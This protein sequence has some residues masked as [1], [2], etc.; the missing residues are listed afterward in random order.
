MPGNFNITFADGTDTLNLISGG[1]V[2]SANNN[3]TIGAAVDSGR[4]TAGG[5]V[6]NSDLFVF[7]NQATLTINSRI[8]DNSGGAV[9]L[10]KSGAG[11]VTLTN[12]ANSY[13]G[14][15]IVNAG[16]LNLSNAAASA[17]IPAGGLTIGSAT[18]TMNGFNNQID[19]LQRRHPPCVR[20]R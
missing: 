17:V 7:N 8:V 5:A 15:T 14:G 20:A 12:P 13:T 6:A 3:N 18:V 16:I 11:S 9:R 4:L 2:K 10:V 19:R 1:L